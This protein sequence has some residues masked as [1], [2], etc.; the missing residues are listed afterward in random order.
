MSPPCTRTPVGACLPNPA[1]PTRCIC[2]DSVLHYART[3]LALAINDLT[4]TSHRRPWWRQKEV[5][6]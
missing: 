4:P 2:C 1:D 6:T 5:R 3:R